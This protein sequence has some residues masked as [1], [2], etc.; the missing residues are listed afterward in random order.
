MVGLLGVLYGTGWFAWRYST[1]SPVPRYPW[2]LGVGLI[3][4]V[5]HVALAWWVYRDATERGLVRPLEWATLTVAMNVFGVAA[6]IAVRNRNTT[7][8]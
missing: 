1:P 4:I 3:I 7:E 2:F 8:E 5:A 6:C